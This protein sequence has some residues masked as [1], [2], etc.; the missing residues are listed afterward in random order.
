VEYV[1]NNVDAAAALV[2]KY[3]IFPVTVAQRAIPHCNITFIE[4][5]SMKKNLSGYINI[6]F[7]QNSQTIGGALPDDEFYFIQ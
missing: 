1:N 4:G 6:L 7:K 5:Q 3:D 2:G